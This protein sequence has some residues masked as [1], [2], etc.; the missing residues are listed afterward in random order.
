MI[1]EEI[2]AVIIIIIFIIIMFC[3]I[4]LGILYSQRIQWKLEKWFPRDDS[5]YV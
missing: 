5:K 3:C 4:I 1:I 2:I